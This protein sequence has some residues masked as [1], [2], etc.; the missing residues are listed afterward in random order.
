M[1]GL[2]VGEHDSST[3]LQTAERLRSCIHSANSVVSSASTTI[4][5]DVT[6]G[7]RLSANLTAQER[8]AL[9]DWMHSGGSGPA[10]VAPGACMEAGGVASQLPGLGPLAELAGSSMSVQGKYTSLGALPGP[11]VQ[12]SEP[13]QR[14]SS[15]PALQPAPATGSSPVL[16]D[17]ASGQATPMKVR[18]EPSQADRNQQP[19][20]QLKG[21]TSQK[22]PTATDAPHRNILSRLFDFHHACRERHHRAANDLSSTVG[23]L[24]EY[25]RFK[26]CFVGDGASGKTCLLV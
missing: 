14:R 4:L 25:R 26:I 2:T 7:H 6:V 19:T 23:V 20:L 18:P 22:A 1:R 12:S 21:T 3:V 8:A 13:R 5:Q 24:S 11:Q 9:L 17:A 15:A 16:H 10:V